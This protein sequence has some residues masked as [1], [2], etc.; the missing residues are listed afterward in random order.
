MLTEITGT[1]KI[2]NNSNVVLEIEQNNLEEFKKYEHPTDPKKF[3]ANFSL[4]NK[5]LWVNGVFEKKEN[6]GDNTVIMPIF[7]VN[8]QGNGK[9]SIT[10]AAI[11]A[12][13]DLDDQKKEVKV[14]MLKHPRKQVE[15]LKTKTQELQDQLDT[16]QQEKQ[17][18]EAEVEKLKAINSTALQQQL[19]EKNAKITELE[20]LDAVA[21]QQKLTEKE[22]EI[23]ALKAQQNTQEVADLQQ[24]LQ[25]KDEEI[26]DL[27]EQ[28][29]NQPSAAQLQAKDEEITQL[30][31]QVQQLQAKNAEVVELNKQLEESKSLVDKLQK[32]K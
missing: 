9:A 26:K 11:K 4:D 12:L 27:Q 31:A 3:S 32:E 30:K 29:N 21:L 24:Q 19:E 6:Q 22:N 8:K 16:A 5:Q 17:D 10:V 1:I 28:L 25:A 23:T 2:V 20:A 7:S 13:L 14:Q 18:L 15:E